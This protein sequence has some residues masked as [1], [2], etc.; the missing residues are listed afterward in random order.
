MSLPKKAPTVEVQRLED[1]YGV[2]VACHD[3]AILDLQVVD[4]GQH[5]GASTRTW[6][7]LWSR[8]MEGTLHGLSTADLRRL[9]LSLERIAECIEAKGGKA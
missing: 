8:G 1:G 5:A 9:A 3:G 2:E 4:E 6:E 7:V